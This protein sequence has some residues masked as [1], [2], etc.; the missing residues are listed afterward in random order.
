MAF[1]LHRNGESVVHDVPTLRSMAHRGELAEDEYVFDDRKGEWLGAATIA[2]LEGAWQ[3]EE[4]EATVA[5]S[6]SPEQMAALAADDPEPIRKAVS[7]ASGGSDDDDGDIESAPTLMGGADLSAQVKTEA[8]RIAAERAAA[9]ERKAAEQREADAARKANAAHKADEERKAAAAA[10]AKRR[11]PSSS[12]IPTSS[13]RGNRRKPA[14]DMP[15][16]KT[17]RPARSLLGNK[18]NIVIHDDTVPKSGG[19]ESTGPRA[20]IETPTRTN[21]RVDMSAASDPEA[22]SEATAVAMPAH[23]DEPA[24]GAGRGAAPQMGVAPASSGSAAPKVRLPAARSG[25]AS[26][27][28]APSGPAP[29]GPPPST[30]A[31]SGP[32][33]GSPAPSSAAAG[34]STPSARP[35]AAASPA[36]TT[37]TDISAAPASAPSRTGLYVGVGVGVVIAIAALA[38]MLLMK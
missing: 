15:R 21:A 25:P 34:D 1:Y 38:A 30:P 35:A 16:R 3:L 36:P 22:T 2:E 37:N 8:A 7:E 4:D 9:A 14:D 5:L 10:D 11:E 26:S 6:L 33:P 24:G 32:P 17:P 27:G 13:S 19:R 23:T 20:A 31:P 18:A 28:P 12:R 29:S